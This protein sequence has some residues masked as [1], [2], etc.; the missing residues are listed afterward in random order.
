ML[1]HGKKCAFHLIQD[2]ISLQSQNRYLLSS[3]PPSLLPLNQSSPS[4]PVEF[5]FSPRV[6]SVPSGSRRSPQ[7][8]ADL[9]EGPGNRLVQFFVSTCSRVSSLF[10]KLIFFFFESVGNVGVLQFNSDREKLH[11]AKLAE[12]RAKHKDYPELVKGKVEFPTLQPIQPTPSV[13]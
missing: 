12:E 8:L 5:F 11:L 9:V 4:C 13:Q 3:T 2:S 1:L 6:A 10:L 7:N